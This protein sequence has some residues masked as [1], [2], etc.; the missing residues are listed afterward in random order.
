MNNPQMTEKQIL[1]TMLQLLQR[2]D[3]K[4]NEVSAWVECSNYLNN[5]I[6]T[7]NMPPQEKVEDKNSKK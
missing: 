1:S 4:G 3:L 5:K 6:A 2:T 7:L